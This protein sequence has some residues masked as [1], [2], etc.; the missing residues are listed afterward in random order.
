MAN[1]T[2]EMAV[3]PDHP[4]E[5]TTAFYNKICRRWLLKDKHVQQRAG[6]TTREIAQ[7]REQR[8][9][10]EMLPMQN[11]ILTALR[12]LVAERCLVNLARL[13]DVRRPAEAKIA[14]DKQNAH[15][16]HND[17]RPRNPPETKAVPPPL[18]GETP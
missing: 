5:C 9:P 10:G 7:W 12:Q 4:A 6:L 3:W 14:F 2:E 13:D 15:L 1:F 16:R 17:F 18:P 11:R 8:W